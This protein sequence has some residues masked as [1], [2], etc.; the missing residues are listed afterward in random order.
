MKIDL[1]IP[2]SANNNYVNVPGRGRVK[3]AA[4]SRWRRV[5]AIMISTSAIPK[6]KK[7]YAV[8]IRANIDHRRDLDNIAKPILDALVESGVIEGD[9]WVNMITCV[10]DRKI[11]ECSVA[12]L[13]DCT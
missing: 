4:Y 12:V 11:K 7:P 5:A 2:P 1:P 10:R 13:G 6:M 8:L 3:S 9:Q